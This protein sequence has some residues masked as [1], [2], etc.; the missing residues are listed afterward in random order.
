MAEPGSAG[1]GIRPESQRVEEQDRRGLW[2]QHGNLLLYSGEDPFLGSGIAQ[3][4]WSIAI[5]LSREGVPRDCSTPRRAAR[6]ASTRYDLH[7]VL[8]GVC[9]G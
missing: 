6:S 3:Q 4:G 5:E 1:A 2:A 7:D 8:A 9:F